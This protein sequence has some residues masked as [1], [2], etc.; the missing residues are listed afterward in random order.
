MFTN[1]DKKTLVDRIIKS[2]GEI[3]LV[4]VN[5]SAGDSLEEIY[6]GTLNEY[7]LHSNGTLELWC[8]TNYEI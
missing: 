4:I 2:K 6:E 1:E 5:S 8:N 3:K 7:V